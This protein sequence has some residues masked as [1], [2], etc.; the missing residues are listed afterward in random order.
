[1]LADLED[2]EFTQ[3]MQ[4]VET[5]DLAQ[6]YEEDEQVELVQ[7]EVEQESRINEMM[8][9][10]ADFFMQT[11][12]DSKDSLG[13]IL[14]QTKAMADEFMTNMQPETAQL[15]DNAYAQT[16]ENAY[17]WLAQLGDLERARVGQMLSQTSY[18]NYFLQQGVREEVADEIG[19]F[20]S[21]YDAVP[22]D[23]EAIYAQVH[24]E[25]MEAQM[26]E[27]AESLAQYSVE[28]ILKLNELVEVKRQ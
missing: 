6:D 17:S 20:F 16:R 10:V 27:A 4:S 19:N 26:E 22:Y 21:Q 1:M 11:D 14:L 25:A 18:G 3:V 15:F 23:E 13:S 12:D 7:T 24:T 2:D 28:Q 9:D 5:D 8:D